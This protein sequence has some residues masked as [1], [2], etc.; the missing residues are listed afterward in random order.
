MRVLQ[1]G[2][3]PDLAEEPLGTECEHKLGVEDLERDR[4]I[5]PQVMG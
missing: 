2:A 4:P 5:V 3:E 1:T